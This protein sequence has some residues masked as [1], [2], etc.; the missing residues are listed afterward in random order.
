MKGPDPVVGKAVTGEKNDTKEKSV[1]IE[2]MGAET[3]LPLVSNR[4]EA[5][6]QTV[7]FKPHASFQ[8]RHMLF[9]LPFKI[10]T[11]PCLLIE[12]YLIIYYLWI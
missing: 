1:G 11:L 3:P 7:S 6:Y 4:T 9:I 12:Y 2:R 5:S 10:L 8:H